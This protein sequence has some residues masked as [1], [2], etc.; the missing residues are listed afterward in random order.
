MSEN[1]TVSLIVAKS[2][3]EAVSASGA[4]L[5][6]AG[7][8]AASPTNISETNGGENAQT[9]LE[10]SASAAPRNAS[11][12]KA[13]SASSKIATAPAVGLPR[14]KGRTADRATSRVAKKAKAEVA[15]VAPLPVKPRKAS[16][17]SQSKA[18]A[19]KRIST[20]K[21]PVGAA[22]SRLIGDIIDTPASASS[23]KGVTAEIEKAV[24][25]T[26]DNT[27]GSFGQVAALTKGNAA[28]IA[29][30]GKVFSE[31]LA[32]LASNCVA[33]GR[34]A[35]VK[36]KADAKELAAIRSPVN[37]MAFNTHILTRN[38]RELVKFGSKNR[39]AI[40][41]VAKDVAAPMAE[42]FSV[43]A[44]SLRPAK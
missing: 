11:V 38:V 44:A 5:P 43:V 32:K 34:V 8:D 12:A 23:K 18:Q 37:L 4:L 21:A 40:V 36:L 35:L 39:D 10:R 26:L 42:R 2:P 17:L 1:S 28:A 27:A 9:T 3:G 7:A 13:P 19:N 29:E 15:E 16:R 30:S 6:K 41:K 31:G 20:A 24:E 33:D 22:A 14:L 25:G